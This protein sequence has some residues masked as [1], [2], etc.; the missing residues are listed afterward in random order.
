MPVANPYVISDVTADHA[1]VVTF[2]PD[3]DTWYLAEGCTAGGVETWVLV[4]N[5]NA[6]PVTL[7]VILRHGRGALQP[8]RPAGSDAGRQDPRVLQRR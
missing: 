6:T 4:E 2:A 8:H 1:V 5:P 3:T 7:D